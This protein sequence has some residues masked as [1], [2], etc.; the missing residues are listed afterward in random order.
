MTGDGG[1]TRD[2]RRRGEPAALPDDE[3]R[4]RRTGGRNYRLGWAILVCT[5][6]ATETTAIITG[7]NLWHNTAGELF[8]VLCF[9]GLIVLGAQLIAAGAQ[10]RSLRP[11]RDRQRDTDVSNRESVDWNRK[12]IERLTDDT[13][14]RYEEI[15]GYVGAVPGRLVELEERLTALVSALPQEIQRQYWKGFNDAVREGFQATGTDGS[16]NRRPHLGLVQPDE[17]DSADD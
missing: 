4:T 17:D 14:R 12:L 6:V 8:A 1:T 5:I 9:V 13:Q 2:L 11:I 10:E 15:M 16:G 3:A 7:N